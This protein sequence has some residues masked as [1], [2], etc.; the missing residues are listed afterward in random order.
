MKLWTVIAIVLLVLG[1][2][3]KEELK[4]EIGARVPA[5]EL[6]EEKGARLY[7]T[8]SASL[9]PFIEREINKVTYVI[10]YDDKTRKIKYLSTDD[11]DFKSSQG[12]KVGDFLEVKGDHVYV[13][14]GWEIRAPGGEDGWEPLIGFNSELTVWGEHKEVKL[15]VPEGQYNLPAKQTIK[16]KNWICKRIGLDAKGRSTTESTEPRSGEVMFF[17]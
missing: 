16:A 9:R 13:M 5:G 8:S 2:Q 15:T 11:P 6:A 12:L 10:A 14:P 3:E 1:G 7:M 17:E 4:L